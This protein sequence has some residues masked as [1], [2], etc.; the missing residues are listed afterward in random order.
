MKVRIVVS[1]PANRGT[2]GSGGYSQI[3]SLNEVSD[4]LRGA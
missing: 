1:D 4:V 3:K 2:I